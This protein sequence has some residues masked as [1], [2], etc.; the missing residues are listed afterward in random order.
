MNGY[1]EILYQRFSLPPQLSIADAEW[2]WALGQVSPSVVT[3]VHS[4]PCSPQ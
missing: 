4:T 1:K 2:E 3:C